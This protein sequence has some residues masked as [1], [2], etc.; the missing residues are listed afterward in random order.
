MKEIKLNNLKPENLDDFDFLN[1]YLI[2]SVM[3][4]KARKPLNIANISFNDTVF[5]QSNIGRSKFQ[6]VTFQNVIFEDCD[7][8]NSAF[9][10]CSFI[11]VVITSSKLYG[12]LFDSAFIDGINITTSNLS[13]AS[14]VKCK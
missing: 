5:K 1:N 9:V 7:L 2:A 12:V 8:S 6:G 3:F 14:I 4:T 11:N 10:N 13:Y